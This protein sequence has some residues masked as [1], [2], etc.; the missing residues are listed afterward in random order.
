MR[1]DRLRPGARPRP[2]QDRAFQRGDRPRMRAGGGAEPQQRMLEQRQQRH[3]RQPAQRRLGRQPREHA[4]RRVGERIAAGIV[5]RDIPALERG[6]DAARQRAVGRDQRRGLARASRPPRAARPR[7]RALPPRHWRLRSRRRSSS[8]RVERAAAKSGVA[9]RSCQWSVAAAGRSASERRRS[10]PCGGRRP[11]ELD[12]VARDADARAAAPAWR[13]ADGRRRASPSRS[14][15][16]PPPISSQER[17]R[18]RCRGRAAPRRRAAAWRW[19]RAAARSPASSRSSRPRSPARRLRGKPRG[20]GLD[21]RV[22]PRRPARWR[23]ARRGS[24]GHGSRAIFR[25][26][27]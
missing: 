6:E 4:G 10:R 5:D 26:R 2:A 7:W 20:F 19:W 22:A 27:A 9:S 3:R 18:D 21:Q 25:N 12:L 16:A 13:I 17:R 15:V 8:A 24:R 23:R 11:S 14:V 1:R